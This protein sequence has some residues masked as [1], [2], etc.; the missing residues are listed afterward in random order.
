MMTQQQKMMG[1]MV[2]H[3]CLRFTRPQTLIRENEHQEKTKTSLE[4]NDD[5][6]EEEVNKWV[7]IKKNCQRLV[8]AG[9]GY[10]YY[11]C[12]TFFFLL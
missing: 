8:V 1:A 3:H 2:P 5:E 6:E 10:S 12:S 7:Q 11:L 9:S 4:R